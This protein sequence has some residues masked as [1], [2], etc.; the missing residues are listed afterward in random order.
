MEVGSRI[1]RTADLDGIDP[2][3]EFGMALD[4]I[5]NTENSAEHGMDAVRVSDS[6]SQASAALSDTSTLQEDGSLSP[7]LAKK[8]KSP[9]PPLPPLPPLPSP[10]LCPR[11]AFLASLILASKFMQDKCYS[12]CTW[13]KLAGLP[14]REIGRCE[15]ALGEALEWRLWV[16]KVPYSAPVPPAA[17]PTSVKR[18]V[19]RSRSESTLLVSPL[20][21]SRSDNSDDL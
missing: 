8:A 5:I 12:N 1:V 15:R 20:S 10:L 19:V 9:C 13:A 21:E 11:R 16:G 14:P 18:P 2:V 17:L 3:A 6:T 7:G 4:S